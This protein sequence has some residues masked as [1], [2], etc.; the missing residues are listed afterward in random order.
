[1]AGQPTSSK[2]QVIAP[3][4]LGPFFWPYTLLLT[5][6]S[7]VIAGGILFANL[8]W[9]LPG[10]SN[11][12]TDRAGDVENLFKFM[13]VFGA[14]ILHLRRRLRGLFRGGLSPPRRRAGQLDRRA[15][16]RL[17]EPQ[18]WWTYVPIVLLIGLVVMSTYIW[19]K[20]FFRP[21]RRA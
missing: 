10:W 15:G 12:V 5:V 18:F 14:W 1:M 17:A 11:P 7:L 6:I 20:I 19:G 9:L 3:K 16:P 2:P 13:G 21:R 4:G 8:D